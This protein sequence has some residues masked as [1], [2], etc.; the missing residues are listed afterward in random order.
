MRHCDLSLFLLFPSALTNTCELSRWNPRFSLVWV[1][2]VTY[3]L[4]L[5]GK[6][7]LWLS[8]PIV[9]LPWVH[10][11]TIPRMCPYSTLARVAEAITDAA[12][13]PGALLFS[14]SCIHHGAAH[15]TEYLEISLSPTS[16]AIL[17]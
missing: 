13:G 12:Q 10:A 4:G 2:R 11:T 7:N 3:L 8:T 17:L 14:S 9:G 15:Q 6:R 1:L 5:G 16:S